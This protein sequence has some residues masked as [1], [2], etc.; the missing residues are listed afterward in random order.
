MFS[1]VLFGAGLIFIGSVMS[2][3]KMFALIRPP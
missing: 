2:H 3:P 1:S